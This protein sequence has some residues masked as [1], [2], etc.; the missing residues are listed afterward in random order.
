MESSKNIDELLQRLVG[1]YAWSARRGYG[2]FLTL[3]F[4]EP[5]RDIREPIQASENAD[6]TVKRT[7]GRRRVSIKGD[8]SLWIRDSQW[9]ISTKDVAVDWTSDAALVERMLVFHLD[10]QKVLSADRRADE[11]VLEFDLGTTLRMGKSMF[12]GDMESALWSIS[13]R[14]GPSASL[15]DGGEAIYWSRTRRDDDAG[16][17][18]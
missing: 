13:L 17:I 5:H 14:E 10:G 9:S 4:G 16:S 18:N 7:L 3:Q 8:I 2:T 15:F 11:T 12:P 1:Q 6:A